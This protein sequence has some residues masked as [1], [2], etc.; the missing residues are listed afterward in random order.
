MASPLLFT[1]ICSVG[2]RFFNTSKPEE[3]ILHPAYWHIIDLVDKQL[4]EMLLRPKTSEIVVEAIQ[5]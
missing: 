2:A 5:A 3:S 4:A 1:M